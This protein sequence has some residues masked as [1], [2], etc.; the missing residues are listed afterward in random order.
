MANG[1]ILIKS[2]WKIIEGIVEYF[3]KILRLIRSYIN[4]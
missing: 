3:D 2:Y 4:L 1:L